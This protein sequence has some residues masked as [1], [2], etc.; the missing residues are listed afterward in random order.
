MS[1]CAEAQRDVGDP[2]AAVSITTALL[3]SQRYQTRYFLDA[4]GITCSAAAPLAVLLLQ[5]Q[6]L[7]RKGLIFHPPAK[8]IEV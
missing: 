8:W 3:Q 7:S 5:Y 1:P 4:G 2:G 6:I